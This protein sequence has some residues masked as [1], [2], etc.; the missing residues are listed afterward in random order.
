MYIKKFDLILQG[1]LYYL[2]NYIKIIFFYKKSN[3]LNFKEKTN[4]L[5]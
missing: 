5:V 2:F 4:L 1:A 3:N